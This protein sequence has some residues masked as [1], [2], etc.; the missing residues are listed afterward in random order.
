MKI[1][2]TVLGDNPSIIYFNK[3][4]IQ[5][6]ESHLGKRIILTGI[7]LKP[8]AEKMSMELNVTANLIASSIKSMSNDE[9]SLLVNLYEYLQKNVRYD[10]DELQAAS[11]GVSISPQSHNAYGAL[12]NKKAVC[13][14]FSSAFALLAQKLG[15]DC[16]LV[17]GDS[18]YSSVS[19]KHAWNIVKTHNSYH[20]IDVTWD[21]RKYEEFG[22]F[23]YAYFALPDCDVTVD[24]NWDE[25]KT[26]ICSDTAFSYFQKNGLLA[27]T[28]EQLKDIIKTIARKKCNVFRIKLSRNISLSGNIA[29]HLGQMVLNEVATFGRKTQA[30]YSWNEKTRC[31]SAKIMN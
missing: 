20:H 7:N 5:I 30:S 13:D 26:P 31:F 28:T 11:R 17:I 6:E 1:M 3:T 22:E 4:K 27:N 16:M 24:H 18:A 8:Q 29:E 9:Y 2:Q 23:S 15:F 14:G 10:K 21:A 19:V 25:I 12:I